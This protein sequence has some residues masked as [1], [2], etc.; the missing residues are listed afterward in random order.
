[1]F[2]DDGSLIGITISNSKDDT[3]QLIYPNINMSI[4]VYDILPILKKYGRSKG[5]IFVQPFF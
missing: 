3:Q 2:T 1:M 5:M 4:P